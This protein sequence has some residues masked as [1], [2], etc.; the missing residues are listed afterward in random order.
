MW[1]R[2]SLCFRR[3]LT[4]K[5][6]RNSFL[7]SWSSMRDVFSLVE[8]EHCPNVGNFSFLWKKIKK[9]SKSFVETFFVSLVVG[10]RV[11]VIVD[12]TILLFIGTFHEKIRHF[13]F[14]PKKIFS[15]LHLVDVGK[16]FIRRPENKSFVSRRVEQ[17]RLIHS[18]YCVLKRDSMSNSFDLQRKQCSLCLRGIW[19]CLIRWPEI[20]LFVDSKILFETEN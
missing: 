19:N 8:F 15:L 12:C 14:V 7:G 3:F 5:N 4:T 10:R 20:R 11:F 9:M 2:F 17:R 18:M 6:Q 13:S 1:N 16:N